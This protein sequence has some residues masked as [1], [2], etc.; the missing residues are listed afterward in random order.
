MGF[1][2]MANIISEQCN[3]PKIKGEWHEVKAPKG[4]ENKT[5]ED[6]ISFAEAHGFYQDDNGNIVC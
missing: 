1:L 2:Q 6:E 5:Y 4:F 3:M